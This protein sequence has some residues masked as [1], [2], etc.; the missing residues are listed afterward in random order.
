MSNPEALLGNILRQCDPHGAL[1]LS[2]KNSL[3]L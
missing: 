3:P 1:L 2:H